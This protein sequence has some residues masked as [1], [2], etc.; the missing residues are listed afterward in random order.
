MAIKQSSLHT[1]AL[2]HLHHTPPNP[3]TPIEPDDAQP[4]DAPRLP[5]NVHW[6]LS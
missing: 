3:V 6:G 2:V 5:Q 1:A 4:R